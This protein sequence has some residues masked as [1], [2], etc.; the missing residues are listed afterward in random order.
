VLSLVD[1]NLVR[2]LVRSRS[3]VVLNDEKAYL[4]ESRLRQ[5]AK[6]VGL[7]S[8]SELV[9]TVRGG[10]DTALTQKMVE[11]MTTNE[12]SFFRDGHPFEALRTILLPD[13]MRRRA[14]ERRLT[15]WCGACSTGQEPYSIAIL[16]KEHFPSLIGWDVR[17]VATDLCTDILARARAGRYTEMEVSRGMPPDLLARYFERVGTGWVVRES[18]RKMVDFRQFNLLSGS[19]PVSS[20]DILFLRNVLIYF[21]MATKHAILERLRT[22]LRLDGVLFLGGTETTWNLHEG[23]ARVPCGRSHY[24]RILNV[25]P[26]T[27]RPKVG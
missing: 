9:A 10:R 27:A 11:A 14:A 3:G 4:A 17:V 15:I 24:Y 23:F 1:F 20:V 5:L 25:A 6:E 19:L 16:L 2:D 13:L 12:T 22:A 8:A 7:A 26:Q 18:V 21:D